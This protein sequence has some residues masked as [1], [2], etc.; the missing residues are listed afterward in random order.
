M[1]SYS[2]VKS[3]YRGMD[4]SACEI[5][6][7]HFVLEV[8]LKHSMTAKFWSDNQVT[9]HIASNLASRVVGL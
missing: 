7:T 9:L 8:G 3:H 5:M 4:N 1:V 2:S 6:W